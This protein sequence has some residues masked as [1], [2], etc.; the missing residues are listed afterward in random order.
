MRPPL[1]S[2]VVLLA[3][4]AALASA[5]PAA[6]RAEAVRW[7]ER[8]DWAPFFERAGVPGTM[9]VVD[10]RSGDHLVHDAKRAAERLPP[11]STFKVPHL[12]F[13]LDAR[14]ARDEFQVFPWDG[15]ERAISEWN[16]DQT[17]RS[18]MR[19]SVVW[20]YQSFARKLGERREGGY[21]RRIGY[22]NADPSGGV[23]RFWLDGNLRISA[24][25]QVAFLQRLHRNALPFRVADQRLVKDVM[26]A[27]AGRS[28]ILRAKTGW[29][30]RRNPQ[31][32][33]WVGWVEHPEGAVFFAL[34]IEMPN[35][36]RDA[37]KRTEIAR[38]ILASL[39]A[40]P[41]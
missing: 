14:I 5:S 40:L 9:V 38:A 20:V 11:A 41:Q 39:K 10:E 8:P 13:A 27:E 19:H 7:T 36:G 28:W 25:E 35:Q 3:A 33:W 23:D 12:L 32:G 31:V 30:G 21:L 1:P 4:V 6:V 16:G 17:I 2:P 24:L 34:A 18:S 26:I 29:A 15:V 22:G 37:P